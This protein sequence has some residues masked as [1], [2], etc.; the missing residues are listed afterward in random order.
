MDEIKWDVGAPNP[1]DTTTNPLNPRAFN[2]LFPSITSFSRNI[3]VEETGLD[4][5]CKCLSD[6]GLDQGK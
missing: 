6:G 3:L 4:T 5:V 2:H 1:T